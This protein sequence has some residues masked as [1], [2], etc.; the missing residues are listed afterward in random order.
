[1]PKIGPTEILL[2]LLTMTLLSMCWAM[3]IAWAWLIWRLITRQ[4]ILPERPMVV[5]GEPSWGAGTVLI[6]FLSYI[7]I[8]FLISVS[9]PLVA[10]KLPAKAAPL[11]LAEAPLSHLML[12]NAVV[13]IV[14]LIVVPV[15]VSLTCGA[16]L[17]DFGLS[18]D[19]WRSQAAVG[20]VASLIAAPP[21]NAIQILAT[22]IWTYQR[23]PVQEMIFKEFSVG[24]AGL[25]V[26][27]A[28]IL[29]P[30][31]EEL[32][33]RGLLQ[34]W[35][36]ALFQGKSD[37]KTPTIGDSTTGSQHDPGCRPTTGQS[38]PAADWDSESEIMPEPD[39]EP[40]SVYEPPRALDSPDSP[41]EQPAPSRPWL[42]IVLTSLLFAS[43]H[44]PQWPAPIALFVLALVIGTVYHRTGSLIVAI[45][46]HATFNGLSTLA[47]F[48]DLVSRASQ[49]K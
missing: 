42:A 45:F 35:L 38:P 28:V 5:G 34:S 17:R 23:H 1:M 31:F 10:D 30:M 33:F 18:L 27:T 36:V 8:S 49:M 12:L 22:R 3:F 15:V 9:Y 29:A 21:V 48:I 46:M 24:V 11:P 41:P 14:M 25:A 16:R 2:A 40:R 43:V 13:E 4:P 20:V 7:G 47:L 26:V 44:A 37:G 6:V 32:L 39:L 19:G